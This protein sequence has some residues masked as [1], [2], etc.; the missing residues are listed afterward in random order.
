MPPPPKGLPVGG[1][2]SPFPNPEGSVDAVLEAEIGGVGA[3][4]VPGP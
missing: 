1:V 2:P 4:G 3:P